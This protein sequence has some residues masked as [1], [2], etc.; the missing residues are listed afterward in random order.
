[1]QV[2]WAGRGHEDV[3]VSEA[4]SRS[5]GQTQGRR[6]A[7]ASSGRQGNCGPMEHGQDILCL[8]I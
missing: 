1:M 4:D 5:D 8:V 7:A 2:L 6:L 3:G